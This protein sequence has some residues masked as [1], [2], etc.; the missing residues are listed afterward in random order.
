MLIDVD[1]TGLTVQEIYYQAPKEDY[2]HYLQE[3]KAAFQSIEWKSLMVSL[4]Y[5]GPLLS[6]SC[7][8]VIL[9]AAKN[10]GTIRLRF[11]GRFAPSE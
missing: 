4:D 5:A 1:G 3:A 11:F 9:S 8:P 6:F 10:L 2:L 7:C